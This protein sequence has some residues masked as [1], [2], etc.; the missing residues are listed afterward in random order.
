MK[1]YLIIGLTHLIF[2]FHIGIILIILFGSFIPEIRYVYQLV[3]GITII[4]WLSSSGCF[5]TVWEYKLRKIIN[6]YLEI[7]EYGFIDYHLRDYLR[8]VALEIFIYRV[9]LLFLIISL[10]ISL[11]THGIAY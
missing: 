1:K 2:I 10:G 9:G 7:Y 5:L 6:P 4:S 11:I 3:L 8:G